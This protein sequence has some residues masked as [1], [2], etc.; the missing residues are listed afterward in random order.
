MN[1]IDILGDGLFWIVQEWNQTDKR[2]VETIF[3]KFSLQ[4]IIVA[5][6]EVS[7]R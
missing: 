4:K 1:I 3:A 2:V 5:V 7:T 6:S